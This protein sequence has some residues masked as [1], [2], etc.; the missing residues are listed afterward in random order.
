MAYL[1]NSTIFVQ[2]ILD[3][4]MSSEPFPANARNI[5]SQEPE[6]KKEEVN[7][8]M[9]NPKIPKEISPDPELK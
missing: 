3:S 9:G 6:K 7:N 4:L 5:H 1:K 8:P 2:E